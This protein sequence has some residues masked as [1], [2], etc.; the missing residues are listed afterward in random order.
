MLNTDFVTLWYRSARARCAIRFAGTCKHALLA[1]SDDP[2]AYHNRANKPIPL[3]A[4]LLPCTAVL[5]P[6]A[7][8]VPPAGALHHGPPPSALG[9]A[10][11]RE[12]ERVLMVL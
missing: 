11:E 3:T 9:A 5:G 1:A 2:T 12:C 4:T 7:A 6:G 10:G 8:C